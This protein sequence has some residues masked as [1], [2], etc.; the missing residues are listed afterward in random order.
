[1]V[2]AKVTLLSWGV[3]IIFKGVV[4]VFKI[5]LFVRELSDNL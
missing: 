3:E 2:L 4:D 1:M 5:F